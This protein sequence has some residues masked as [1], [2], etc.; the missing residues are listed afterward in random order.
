MRQPSIRKHTN[1]RWGLY[2]GE[3]LLA[4]AKTEV[5][6]DIGLRL[7]QSALTDS[8]DSGYQDGHGEGYDEGH[9]DAE[10]EQDV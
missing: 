1:G 4:T 7:L 8:F 2:I 9:S 6:A 3:N 10:M 5:R